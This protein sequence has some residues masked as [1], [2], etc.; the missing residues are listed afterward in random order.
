M[1]LGIIV[2]ELFA[3]P[4]VNLFHLTEQ[5]SSLCV[6]AIRIIAPGFLLAGANI[7]LQGVFQALGSGIGSLVV[8]L[9]RLLVVVLPLAWAFTQMSNASFMIW[10]AFP[11]AE[12]AAVVAAVLFMFRV[13]RKIA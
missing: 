11:I 7:A 4:L 5:T 8:S 12:A 2:L 3:E 6:L 1:L 10:F 9:L 13:R